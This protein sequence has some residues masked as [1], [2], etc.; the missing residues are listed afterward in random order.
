MVGCDIPIM[1]G[2]PAGSSSTGP[3]GGACSR[4]REAAWPLCFVR[5]VQGRCQVQAGQTR[6]QKS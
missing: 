5:L 4:G 1:G 3:S 6:G 2:G